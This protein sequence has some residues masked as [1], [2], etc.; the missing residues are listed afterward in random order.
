MFSRISR[1]RKVPDVTAPDARGR[2]LAAKDARLLP[3]VSGEFRHMVAAGDRLDQLAF[4][5]YSE[6]LQWWNICDGN[7]EFLSPLALLGRDGV[8]TTRFPV[9]PRS[10]SSPSSPPWADLFRSVMAILG[11]E[12]V[13][14]SEEVQLVQEKVTVGGHA[15][16]VWME[17]FSRAALVTYNRRNVTAATVAAGIEAA[18][19]EVAPFTD[20]DQ[21]GREIT[22]P[23]KPIG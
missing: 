17:R 9:A 10:V 18:G 19:F 11:V 1:Y 15:K 8:I 5:Y 4:K 7:P 16:P 23:P 20:L 6:P 2:L 14:I 3:T 22:I 12:G 13:G 21:L